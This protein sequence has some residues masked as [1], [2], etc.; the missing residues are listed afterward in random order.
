MSD[1]TSR[2]SVLWH[3][4]LGYR[5]GIKTVKNLSAGMVVIWMQLRM[6]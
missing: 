5:K 3:W 2:S 4:W 6:S 1:M